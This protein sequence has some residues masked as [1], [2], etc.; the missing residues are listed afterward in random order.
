[1]TDERRSIFFSGTTTDAVLMSPSHVAVSSSGEIRQ[2]Q[3]KRKEVEGETETDQRDLEVTG[4]D[5][6]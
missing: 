4:G 5:V 2:R 1:M 3:W 6:G